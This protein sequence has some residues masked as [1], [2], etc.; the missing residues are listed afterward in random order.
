MK[1][2]LYLFISLLFG[3]NIYAQKDDKISVITERKYTINGQIITEKET[4]EVAKS[5]LLKNKDVDTTKTYT[6]IYDFKK[7]EYLKSLVKP[8]VDR[9]IVYKVININRLAFDVQVNSKDVVVAETDWFT[10][11][12]DLKKITGLLNQASPASQPTAENIKLP[13]SK[14]DAEILKDKATVKK[15][16]GLLTKLEGL[17]IKL[18]H[19]QK[20]VDGLNNNKIKYDYYKSIFGDSATIRGI[21]KPDDIII[22]EKEKEIKTINEDIKKLENLI[23]EKLDKFQIAKNNF[24][25]AYDDF[26]KSYNTVNKIIQKSNRVLPIATLPFLNLE[27]Y[28]LNHQADFRLILVELNVGNITSN[29][30]NSQYTDLVVAYNKLKDVNDLTTYFDETSLKKYFDDIDLLMDNAKKIKLKGE[31]INF[32]KLAQQVQRVI[33]LL[34]KNETY[35]YISAPIQPKNDMATFDVVIKAKIKDIE[36]DNSRSF[37]HS[38]SVKGGTRIDFSIGLA[39]SYFSNTNV[40][41]I[42]TINGQNKIGL[43]SKNLTVPSLVTMISMTNRTTKYGAIGGSAGL[44]IDT[45]NG[46]I[47]LS[48]FFIGPTLILGKYDRIMLTVGAAIRNV[49]KL[50]N[51]YVINDT[52]ITQSSDI[53][54]VLSD[55]YKV[56]FFIGLTYN[57]TNNVRNKISNYKP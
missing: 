18:Q 39:A 6:V 11:A 41:E 35:E 56:G 3:F 30:I 44:G 5:K 42:Y 7:G 50:K 13:E 1:A 15:D 46:K 16:L 4:V 38:V 27:E 24:T 53:T 21:E 47:Q 48:N 40:Y 33:H 36:V 34:E 57:L 32:E 45:N 26:I 2:I 49:G 37:T 25:I 9:P 55:N 22:K 51:G 17:N 43:K 14:S 29:T 20:V 23:N 31:L 8:K 28:K 12:E 54:T 52:I 19:E 10:S